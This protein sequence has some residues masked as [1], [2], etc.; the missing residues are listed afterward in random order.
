MNSNENNNKDSFLTYKGYPL[1]RKQDELY[2]GNM[3]DDYFVRMQILH[4]QS[5]NGIN[6]ADKI[7]VY[8]VSTNENLDI[9]KAIIRSGERDSLYEALDLA[10]AWLKRKE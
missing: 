4:K 3:S 2:F 8:K 1:V 6:I 9:M 10:V 5:I 7:M